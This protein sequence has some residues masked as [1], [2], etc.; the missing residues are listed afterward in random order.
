MLNSLYYGEGERGVR[1]LGAVTP[2]VMEC[3]ILTLESNLVS[4]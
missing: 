1:E 2:S 4:L 3:I